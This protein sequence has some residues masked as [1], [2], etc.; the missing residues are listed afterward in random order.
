MDTTQE[1][2]DHDGDFPE[3][4]MPASTVTLMRESA[5]A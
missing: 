5:I 3:L 2:D 4:E 1:Q